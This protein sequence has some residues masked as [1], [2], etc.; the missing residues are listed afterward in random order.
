MAHFGPSWANFGLVDAKLG[1]YRASSG[2][3][4][5]TLEHNWNNLVS[6]RPTLA[7]VV[8]DMAKLGTARTDRGVGLF[9]D[10]QS[11]G[12]RLQKM[13]GSSIREGTAKSR[14]IV[15]VM[16]F[17]STP[18]CRTLACRVYLNVWIEV[19]VARPSRGRLEEE[20]RTQIQPFAVRKLYFVFFEFS[21]RM[22]GW[23]TAQ[24][25]DT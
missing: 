20:A 24:T 11:K 21:N 1:R 3:S 10:P 19:G 18:T 9:G 16:G 12:T 14:G 22:E 6:I 4:P 25:S 8:L 15:A 2:E 23:R 17:K 5:V 7:N 13:S